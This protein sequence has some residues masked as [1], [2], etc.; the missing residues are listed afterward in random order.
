MVR[1]AVRNLTLNVYK[2][3]SPPP[4]ALHMCRTVLLTWVRRQRFPCDI[5]VENEGMRTFIL[6]RTTAPY[7][8]NI[9]WFIADKCRTLDRLVTHSSRYCASFLRYA[10]LC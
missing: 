2:G 5:A 7:F 3:S 9:V 1:T 10:L 6:D 8:S 4:A